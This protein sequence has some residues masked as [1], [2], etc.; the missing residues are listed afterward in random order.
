MSFMVKFGEL[1]VH[2][3][4]LLSLESTRKKKFIYQNALLMMMLATSLCHGIS[5]FYFPFGLMPHLTNFSAQRA[6]L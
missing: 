3:V 6:S 2:K 1:G 5:F 4:S